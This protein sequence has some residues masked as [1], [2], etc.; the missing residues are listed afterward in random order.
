MQTLSLEPVQK[1]A[2]R[3]KRAIELNPKDPEAHAYYSWLLAPL[4]RKN[5]ALEEANRALK[6]DP[7]SSLANFGVGS[8][9]VFTRQWNPA[10]D[11]LRHAK[12]IDPTYWFDSCFLGRVY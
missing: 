3:S 11:Q 9:L 4:G 12:E 2:V 10:I 5:E 7:L 6:A 8:V 1:T